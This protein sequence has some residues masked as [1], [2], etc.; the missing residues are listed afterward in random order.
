MK[1]TR[2]TAQLNEFINY[3]ARA[4]VRRAALALG[5]VVNEV[6]RGIELR[7]RRE[8]HS[9]AV[10]DEQL[11]IEADE[12]LLR[13]A[14][15]N[16]LINAVQASRPAAKSRSS[17]A[18]GT[19]PKP[20]EVRDNGQGVA[21]EHRRGNLQT[22][23]H[24]ARGRPGLRSPVVPQIVLAHGGVDAW[25]PRRLFRITTA[26]SRRKVPDM[27]LMAANTTPKTPRV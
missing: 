17:P 7:Y 11:V 24:N 3:S 21:P 18:N 1:P 15:F 22:L 6:V 9:I 4:K 27:H 25:Q 2:V 5:S 26:T 10:V 8:A 23:F 20:L 19:P 14:L 12:Q 16:L 13:Q